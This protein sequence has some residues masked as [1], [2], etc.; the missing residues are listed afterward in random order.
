LLEGQFFNKNKLVL[1]L[2]KCKMNIRTVHFTLI[3]LLVLLAGCRQEVKMK[4]G[5]D[6]MKFGIP[7]TLQAPEGV[8]ATQ[9]GKGSTVDVRVTDSKGY[10]IQVFMFDATTSDLKSLVSQKK[11]IAASH[12]DFVKIVEEYED[13]FLYEK[14]SG[15]QKSHD[16]FLIRVSGDKE[17]N[18][19]CGNGGNY[20]E[21][22]V[23]TM[24]NSIRS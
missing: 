9:Q 1:P 16:F 17:I 2:I 19:Q 23:K 24:I 18:F 8:T 13:G 21:S 15:A 3:T 20:S 6:L 11:E 10:D 12:P 14:K 5:F 22:Q 4:G 7:V